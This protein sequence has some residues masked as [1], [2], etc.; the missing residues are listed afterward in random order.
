MIEYEPDTLAEQVRVAWEEW[1]IRDGEAKARKEA[2]DR[3][4]AQAMLNCGDVSVSKAKMIADA[5]NEYAC[6]VEEWIDAEV[7]ANKAKG[8]REKLS[9]YVDLVR[10]K[11]ASK[12]E[13][14]KRLG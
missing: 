6:A 7:E 2:A 13:E 1:A 9:I 11:E 14:L 5:S 8:L 12:R 4:H 10:S 3:I